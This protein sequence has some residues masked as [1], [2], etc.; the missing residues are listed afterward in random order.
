[1]EF[2]VFT[3]LAFEVWGGALHL[4]LPGAPEKEMLQ[5]LHRHIRAMEVSLSS[6]PSPD[7]EPHPTISI[8]P[9]THVH[10]HVI[11][12]LLEVGGWGLTI[13]KQDNISLV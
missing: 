12:A 13:S 3:G 9:N 7:D 11:G 6:I 5:R 10:V 2:E 1:M 4:D 8:P